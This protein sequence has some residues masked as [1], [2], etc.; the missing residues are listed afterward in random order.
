MTN[1][2][3]DLGAPPKGRA[4][5]IERTRFIQLG[6]PIVK[7]EDRQRVLNDRIRS[8]RPRGSKN[9]GPRSAEPVATVG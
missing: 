5:P 2:K 1:Y 8:K 7:R 9:R 3:P 6:G 4:T